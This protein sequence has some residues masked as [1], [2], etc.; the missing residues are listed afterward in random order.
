MT[1]DNPENHG[2]PGF[3]QNPV[4]KSLILKLSI[5]LSPAHGTVWYDVTVSK[6]V[7]WVVRQCHISGCELRWDGICKGRAHR[8]NE[9]KVYGT[10]WDGIGWNEIGWAVGRRTL[11]KTSTSVKFHSM[12]KCNEQQWV[13]CS[14]YVNPVQ[15]KDKKRWRN[16]TKEKMS[17]W[18]EDER[19]ED[20]LEP[21]SPP[22]K[23]W[24]L[25]LS[26][27]V[28]PTHQCLMHNSKPVIINHQSFKWDVIL[29]VSYDNQR[30]SP[31]K[32]LGV[33]WRNFLLSSKQILQPVRRKIRLNLLPNKTLI[34]SRL[35]KVGPS[36]GWS[37]G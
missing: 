35:V 26:E 37:L 15:I 17:G 30:S 34:A 12:S 14:Y 32:E 2:I 27:R 23:T 7:I 13:R 3:L 36:T 16:E 24:Q 31:N 29:S 4:Q 1:F 19:V 22:L 33:S 18:E 5:S 20:Q 25:S 21:N 6:E 8:L 28:R 9:L 10:S 11:A